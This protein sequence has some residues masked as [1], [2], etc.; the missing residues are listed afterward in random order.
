MTKSLIPDNGVFMGK[1]LVATIYALVIQLPLRIEYV[2]LAGTGCKCMTVKDIS[3]VIV[4]IACR[5]VTLV[6]KYGRCY[7]K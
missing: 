6:S 7:I 3:L 5:A 1:K 4:S 2:T